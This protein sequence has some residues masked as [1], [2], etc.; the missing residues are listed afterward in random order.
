L[1]AHANSEKSA[2]NHEGGIIWSETGQH[3]YRR[4]EDKINYQRQPSSITVGQE[5]EDERPYRPKPSVTAIES[6]YLYQTD[7]TPRDCGERKDYQKKIKR[8]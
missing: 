2:K 3:L 4:V 8:Y 5:A 6:A 7:G 1:A